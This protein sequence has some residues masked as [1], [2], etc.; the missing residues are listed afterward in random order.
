MEDNRHNKG[1]RPKLD[2]SD[3]RRNRTLRLSDKEYDELK[4]R[5]SDNGYYTV[6]SY[7][8]HKLFSRQ[9]GCGSLSIKESA[10]ID[11][12]IRQMKAIGTN[13]NQAVRKINSMDGNIRQSQAVKAELKKLALMM[14]E[15]SKVQSLLKRTIEESLLR[16]GIEI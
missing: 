15:A 4:R 12:A 3:I 8:Q 13:I 1:G 7:I 9:T 5:A 11:K 2:G 6:A 14:E 10:E 16:H